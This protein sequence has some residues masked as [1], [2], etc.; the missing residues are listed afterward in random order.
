MLLICAMKQ[1]VIMWKPSTQCQ[2]SLALPLLRD[3]A[4]NPLLIMPN[5]QE[6]LEG[7]RQLAEE[8]L[9]SL[10]CLFTML[11]AMTKP[12][13]PEETVTEQ[14]MEPIRQLVNEVKSQRMK[15]TELSHLIMS[16]QQCAPVSP[17]SLGGPTS[18]AW[19]AIEMEAEANQSTE[20]PGTSQAAQVHTTSVPIALG[21]NLMTSTGQGKSG[22]KIAGIPLRG[23]HSHAA[24]SHSADNQSAN[25]QNQLALTQATLDSWGNKVVTWGKKHK[26]DTYVTTYEGD[27]G[28]VQWILAR[29]G[30][31]N[32]E[33]EDFA[34]YA[35]TRRRLEEAAR[36][37]ALR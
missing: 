9:Q 11:F 23:H 30:S 26:G 15:I 21:Q 13:S 2:V 22:M 29:I 5:R 6:V 1:L 16:Q 20:V 12:L 25:S 27:S 17:T 32:T 35:I 37:Q 3:S 4:L 10:R 19:E 28:Y 34:N 7:F 36:Q 14:E 24:G 31:L 33:L 18:D 8:I